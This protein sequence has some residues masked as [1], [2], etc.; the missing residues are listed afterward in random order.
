MKDGTH[1]T[2]KTVKQ[3]PWLLSAKNIDNN[4][5]VIKPNDRKIS[6]NAF[7]KIHKNFQLHKGDVLLT[8]VGTIGRSA[9]LTKTGNL[10]FQRSVAYLRPNNGILDPGYLL[11]L[12]KSVNFQKQ[13]KRKVVVSAQPGI[14]LNDISRLSVAIP[15]NKSEQNK[16]SNL[17]ERINDLLS[18]QQKKLEQIK[19]LKKAMLQQIFPDKDGKLQVRFTGFTDAWEQRK[20]GEVF[21]EYSEKNHP[22]LPA[23]TIIQ[24]GGTILRDK[25]DRHLQYKSSSLSTYKLVNPND[26]IVHLRSFEG[27]LEKATNRGIISPAY[28]TFHGKNIDSQF[29]YA[30]F[31]SNEFI[32]HALVPHVYGIR[33]GRSIDINGMKSINIPWANFLEQQAIGDFIERFDQLIALH[34]RKLNHLQLL[35]KFLLVDYRMKLAT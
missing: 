15:N 14:Y 11:C 21:E 19:L 3:G 18:L 24:G 20:L 28:H 33:D 26:F 34:Q 1:G 29:Y 4:R 9:I 35:K 23:L 5:I 12:T 10:T 25:S 31:R 16:I 32:H 2:H 8:I 22:E 17:L 30:Y 27:G 13:L 6:E 7:K